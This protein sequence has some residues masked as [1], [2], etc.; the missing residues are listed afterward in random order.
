MSLVLDVDAAA[1]RTHLRAYVAAHP[2]VVPV[3]KG[4]GYGFGRARL[5]DEAAALGVDT[6]AAGT[7]TEAA[8]ALAH[9]AFGTVT[10]LE[11]WR[12]SPAATPTVHG[13]GGGAASANGEQGSA[14]RRASDPR[15]AARNAPPVATGHVA[16]VAADDP[17]LLHT[18][19][20]VADLAALAVGRRRVRVAIEVLTSMRRHGVD[21]DDVA[22]LGRQL[23]ALGTDGVQVE[24]AAF[25]LPIDRP[26]GYDPVAEVCTWLDRL[27]SAGLVV[28]TAY[29]SHLSDA[30][31]ADLRARAPDVRLRPR[32]G[33]ALWLGAGA[34]VH[35]RARVVD[36]RPVRRGDRTGYRQRRLPADGSLVV[37]SGGTAH[38]IGLDAFRIPR[39]LGRA[40]VFAVAG[41][42]AA[43]MRLSP[44]RWRGAQR[45]YAEP[46][47]MQVSMLFLPATVVPPAPGDWLD[48]DCRKTTTAFDEIRLH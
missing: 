41:L 47:H 11:P 12:P 24:A 4:N 30:E 18:V 13:A 15:P 33:T 8:E 17:R 1:W 2:D 37:V 42:D 9:G 35:A 28:S 14:H 23:R 16:S 44:F 3:V 31:T 48:V 21:A 43:G 46:P 7:Y 36:V 25:H 39:G 27:R 5:L 29:T 19:G 6:V 32:V 20:R 26:R 40:R 10:V 22:A 34:A 45:W 38:G